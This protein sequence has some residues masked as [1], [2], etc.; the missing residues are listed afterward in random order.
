MASIGQLAA[1]V[2][3]EINNPIGFV[4]SNLTSLETYLRDLFTV[5]E[6]CEQ[7]EREL[8]GQASAPRPSALGRELDLDFLKQDIPLLLGESREGIARVKH[9]VQSLREFARIDSGDDWHWETPQRCLDTTLEVLRG[10]MSNKIEVLREYGETPEIECLPSH[11]NQAFMNILLNATQAIAGQ[12]TIRVRTGQDKE[13]VWVEIGDSGC[14]IA[15]ENLPHIFE[16]FFT[17]RPVGSGTGLGLSAAF[18]IVKRHQ[19]RIEVDSTPGKGTVVRI[20]LPIRR[21]GHD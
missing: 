1:G 11:L 17:T 18:S 20:H 9:I 13:Q 3:H 14:G 8:P 12:G 10:A 6:A 7:M 4:H 19:G 21:Q 5:L 2:A 15:P 16:P